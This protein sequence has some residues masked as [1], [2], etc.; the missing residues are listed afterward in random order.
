MVER[1]HDDAAGGFFESP[2]DADGVRVRLKDGYDGAELA[3]NSVAAETLWRLGSLL[4][5]AEWRAHAQRTFAFF[6]GRLAEG[7]VAMPWLISAMERAAEPPKSLVIAGEKSAADT[8]ELVAAFESKFR[9]D[10]D[11]LVVDEASRPRLAG[12]APFAAKLPA[13]HG[14]ATAYVCREFAC[15]NPVHE[16]A[17]LA[18]LLEPNS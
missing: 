8:R 4:E 2:P 16:P 17:Q 9:P 13:R 3:G 5:R 18:A 15:E 12:L 14:R 7:P 10:D 11:L 1:F 6:S